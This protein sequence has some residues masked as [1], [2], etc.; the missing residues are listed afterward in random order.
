MAKRTINVGTA[1]GNLGDGDTLRD[2]FVK[3]NANFNELYTVHAV[4]DTTLNHDN[5][6]IEGTIAKALLD[7]GAAGGG[8]VLV[9]PGT[10]VCQNTT[11]TV[12]GNVILKGTSRVATTIKVTGAQDGITLNSWF[13]G[14]ESL[15]LEMPTFSSGDGIKVRTNYTHFRDLLITGVDNLSWGIN[16][17]RVN[18]CQIENV[19][20]GTI[21]P[22]VFMGN[23]IIYQN[24]DPG[25][26]PF[27]F[28]DS[29]LVKVDI[30]LWGNNTTGIK[31]H[32]PDGSNNVIN[33]VLLSQVEVLAY[34]SPVGCIGL[35]LRNAKRIT[36]NHVDLEN[37]DTAILEESAG[38]GNNVSSNNVFIAT[39]VFGSN[40]SYQSSG[41]VNRRL[42]LGCDNLTPGPLADTDVMLPKALWLSDTNCRIEGPSAGQLTIDDGDTNNGLRLIVDTQNPIIQPESASN[43]AL[44]RLGRSGSQGVECLPGIVLRPNSSPLA[45]ATDGTV[46]QFNAGVVGASRGLYQLRGSTWVFIA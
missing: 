9:G 43:T 1:P 37:L 18:V 39:F 20:M 2:A 36:C 40:N 27:N 46:A 42:F 17:D 35:H 7:A 8:L 44:L 33:N 38:T 3:T 25:S 31:I 34:N 5:P 22:R 12:P 24:T 14:V 4:V 41:V 32:G 45:N 29:L 10:F 26:H 6:A 21:G 28:G 23:G 11:L 30:T 19:A 15:M 13:S 16:L